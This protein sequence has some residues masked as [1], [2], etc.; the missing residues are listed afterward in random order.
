MV[1]PGFVETEITAGG[2]IGRDGKPIGSSGK[3]PVKMISAVEC[4]QGTCP[5]THTRP[6][7]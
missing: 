6:M 4:A 7:Y 5:N 3:M 1:C 2:G